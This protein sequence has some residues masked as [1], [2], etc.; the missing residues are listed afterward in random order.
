MLA[1][2]ILRTKAV[3]DLDINM[4]FRAAGLIGFATYVLVYALVG[5][6]VLRGDSLF[7][8][9]GNTVAAALVLISNVSEF[10]LASVLIQ[11][12]FIIIGMSAMIL[13][14]LEDTSHNG[15]AIEANR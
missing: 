1:P 7:F 8:F 4:I 12:F 3:I 5:W 10:N 15:G 2:P 9:A 11:I 6:R 13:R 14:F